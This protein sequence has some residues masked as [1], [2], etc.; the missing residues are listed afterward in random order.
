MK[1]KELIEK[2]QEFNGEIDEIEF[3]IVNDVLVMEI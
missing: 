2:L 3:K 1:V